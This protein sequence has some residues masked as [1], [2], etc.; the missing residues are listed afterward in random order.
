MNLLQF[1]KKNE[2]TRKIFGVRELKIIEKQLLGINL[3]QSEKNRLSRDIRKKFDFIKEISKYSYA[4]DLK[5][6]SVIKER[7][8]KAKELILSDKLEKKIKKI[9]LFGSSVKNERTFRSDIDIA[10]EFDEIDNLE[11]GKFRLRILGEF[12]KT[13]DIQVFNVLPDKIKNSI[14]KNHKVLYKK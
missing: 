8:E 9:Y 1:I 2:N 13:I 3:T 10:V 5:K 14:I 11:A 12:D 7:I 4:L 6:G